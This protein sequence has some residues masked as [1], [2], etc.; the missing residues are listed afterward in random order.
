MLKELNLEN[1]VSLLSEKIETWYE[2]AVKSLP[3]LF[4]AIVILIAFF[5]LSKL[6]KILVR[7][8]IGRVTHSE[9]LT[10][11]LETL[12]FIITFIIG[13]FISLE[14]LNLDKTVTSILA[15]AGVIGLALGFAFQEIASNFISGV[16]IAFRKPYKIGDIVKAEDYIGKVTSINLRTTTLTSLQGLDIII[17]NKYLFTEPFINYTRTHKRRIDLSVGVSYGDD[18]DLVEKVTKEALEKNS[19][20][21]E[22]EDVFVYFE[23]FGDSSI[24]LKACFWIEYPGDLNYFKAKS[25][26]ISSI[27]KAYDENDI[28]IPF[29]IRTLDFGIKG[30]KD[31]SE[32]LKKD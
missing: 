4:V 20:K 3:N 21:L 27:K 13:L 2:L 29:P 31:L 5:Y 28:V 10:G 30:G 6:N 11:L 14:I 18:L 8:F 7:K 19:Y 26:A 16:M 25:E 23:E 24:N 32:S 9:A 17:P 1:A 15:G 22:H 12:A